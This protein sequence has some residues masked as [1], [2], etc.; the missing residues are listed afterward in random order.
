MRANTTGN[1]NTAS[2]VSAL[3]ANTT[4]CCNTASGVNALCSST[5]GN[6]NTASGV[7]ALLANT[8]GCNNTA[9]GRSALS[10]NTTGVSNTARG[11]NALFANTTGNNNTA[12]GVNALCSSTTGNNNTASGVNALLANTTGCNNIGIG[13]NAGRT[14][15]SPAGIVNITTESNRI[16]M[17]ND[18][19]TCA[20]IKIA[21][22]ATSDCRD[23]TCLAPIA[24]GLDFVRALKPTEYQ[25][26]QGGR[27]SEYTDGKRRYGFLAQ[28]VLL[29]EGDDPVI[30]SVDDPDKLQ[31]TEAHLIP[32]L[33]KAI[34]EL[35]QEVQKLK[36][37]L[38]MLR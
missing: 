11:V 28:D 35:A 3:F 5:T 29:L 30:I 20:Q 1:F 17:G 10:E 24:I 7:N 14:G 36:N 2:G 9:S 25:F 16:V 18:D 31:Y 26:R 38:E 34:Q 33:V 23:K 21:W 22:T 13:V 15:G 27:D 4:G 37:D 12:S 6:S 32:V 8:T 19:H